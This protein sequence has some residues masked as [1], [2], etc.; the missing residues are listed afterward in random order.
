MAW[1]ADSG[2]D[3]PNWSCVGP[4]VVAWRGCATSST[5]LERPDEWT[6][7]FSKTKDSTETPDRNEATQPTKSRP[8][9]IATRRICTAHRRLAYVSADA[10]GES[11]TVRPR[12]VEQLQIVIKRQAARDPCPNSDRR[13]P[14]SDHRVHQR[15]GPP[16]MSTRLAQRAMELRYCLVGSMV[17][18]CP[19]SDRYRRTL[20][21]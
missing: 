5:A 7:D 15:P 17:Y 4:D 8:S 12:N 6:L 14:M 13:T 9:K 10:G 2:Q 19:Q 16:A 21:C 3:E 1:G 11:V 18:L 20:C